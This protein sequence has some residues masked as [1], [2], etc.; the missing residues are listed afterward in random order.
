MCLFRQL[1]RCCQELDGVAPRGARHPAF[2]VADAAHADPCSLR[3]LF[4]GQARGPAV[5]S[6]ERPAGGTQSYI[7]D[8]CPSSGGLTPVSPRG[9][10]AF[11]AIIARCH[12]RSLLLSPVILP[13]LLPVLPRHRRYR[14][15]DYK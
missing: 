11:G 2:E 7:H 6:E 4:L 5:T 14:E 1:E 9:P 8:S 10:D 3:Q 13:V 15:A 12:F